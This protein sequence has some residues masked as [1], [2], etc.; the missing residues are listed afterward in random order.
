MPVFK[1]QAMDAAGAVVLGALAADSP[2]E[3]RDQLRARRLQVVELAEEGSGGWRRGGIPVGKWAFGGRMAGR[4]TG[5]IRELSTLLGVGIPLVEALDVVRSQHTGAYETALLKLRDRVAGGVSL[6][7]AMAEQSELFDE[8][9][10]RMSEVGENAGNLDVVFSQLADFKERAL[11]LKDR[12]FSALLY[13]AVVL[14]AALGVSLLL[15]TVVVPMLLDNLIQAGRPLPW[16]T[17]VLKAVSDLLL[18]DGWWVALATA[19][20]GV[21]VIAHGRSLEGKFFWHR[22][23]L[24]LPVVGEMARKQSVA[25]ISMV[26]AVLLR[27]GIDL[28]KALE[29]AGRSIKNVVLQTAIHQA[30]EAIGTGQEVGTAMERQAVF[31][32]VVIQVFAVG[33]Q[34]GRL[35]EMLERLSADY[36]RQVNSL[37]SRLA[38][39]IEPVLILLLSVFV[40]FILFATILPILEAGNVL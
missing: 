9:T 35:E 7:E 30:A 17:R 40:G 3:A 37:S 29:I 25:R 26:I 31:S 39:V 15:M 27:S 8:L 12:V 16:P 14:A 23:V 38:S 1:Y 21:G 5:T 10:I 6:A 36:D 34:T 13:P 20:V 24:K 19:V 33:Q 18:R 28:L 22:L 4:L 2:R 11:E 32:P